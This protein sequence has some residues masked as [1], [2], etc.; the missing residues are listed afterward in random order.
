MSM[1]LLPQ[2]HDPCH[3]NTPTRL[4]L[5][6]P[7]T[8]RPMTQPRHHLTSLR[9]HL[10]SLRLRPTSRINT[11][12]QIRAG[13]PLLR[14]GSLQLRAGTLLLLIRHHKPPPIACLHLVQKNHTNPTNTHLS[15]LLQ[16][17][18][19]SRSSAGQAASVCPNSRWILTVL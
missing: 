15:P 17:P 9:H 2:P 10:T 12:A 11:L 14:A 1:H 3:P 7:S 8:S 16:R 18:T 5:L 19:T 4:L 13:L 6:L